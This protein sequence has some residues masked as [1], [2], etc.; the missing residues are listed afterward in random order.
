M[1]AWHILSGRSA[2]RR[3]SRRLRR[4]RVLQRA[5]D[6]RLVDG[7]LGSRQD[8]GHRP[9]AWRPDQRG[10]VPARPR[11]PGGDDSRPPSPLARSPR[12]LRQ[13]RPLSALRAASGR[14][15][16]YPP[17]ELRPGAP[18][19]RKHA[20]LGPLAALKKVDPDGKLPL[21]LM[22]YSRGGGMAV[23]MA[24]LAPAL[25]I[26]PRA[27]LGVF[28]ADME[29]LI[30]FTRTPH[31]LKVEFLVGD[32]DTVVGDVGAHRLSDRLI[33]AG[34]PASNIRVRVVRSPLG[35]EATH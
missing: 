22:G 14:S 24:G 35:F 3:T 10:R 32:M 6:G 17:Y 1:C 27:V 2:E 4:H 29:P 7:G 31:D 19:G 5:D 33:S 20:V 21:V 18:L 34:F 26:A 11:R 16:I 28:P 13:L 25:D 23:E 8:M 12:P 9:G 15:S 30:D